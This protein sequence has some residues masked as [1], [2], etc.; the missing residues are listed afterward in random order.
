ME[1][2]VNKLT[3][4]IEELVAVEVVNIAIKLTKE[5]NDPDIHKQMDIAL[6]YVAEARKK[7]KRALTYHT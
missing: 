1:L 5:N 7:I 2:A 6:E 3:Q 4:I